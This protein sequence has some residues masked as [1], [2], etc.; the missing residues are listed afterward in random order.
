MNN[1]PVNPKL[2]GLWHGG[3]Y[4]PD[5][6]LD[7]P[8]ILEADIRL[9]KQAKCNVL[10]VG[11]FSWAA[12]EP[13]EGGFEFGWLDRVFDAFEANGLYIDLATP[14]IAPPPWMATQYPEIRRVDAN[15]RRLDF[16]VRSNY[17][18][19]S[20]I[21]RDKV[22]RINTELAKRYGHREALVLW[23]VSNEYAGECHCELCQAAFREF[24]KE[25]HGS[26][27]A[28][29]KAWWT[30]FSGNLYDSWEQISSPT[31]A[32]T[33]H[34][35]KLD[36]RRF[37]TH[38]ACGFVAN[39]LAPLREFSPHVPTTT[40]SP[41]NGLN[42]QAVAACLD[43]ASWDSYPGFHSPSGNI[44]SAEHQALN[45]DLMRSVKPGRPFL[46][47]E[48]TP[49]VHCSPAQKLKR[50]GMHRTAS[51]LAVASGSDGVMYFQWRKSRGGVEKFH[52]AVV[53]HDGGDDT[54]TFREVAELGGTLAK[55]Q[56]VAGTLVK[57]EAAVVYDWE[58]Q[59]A[60]EASA[61]LD[62][63][64]KNYWMDFVHP[65]HKAFFELGVATDVI[66]A[67]MPFEPYKLIVAPTLY[68]V[69]EGVAE[70]LERFVA[71]GGTLV[72]TYWSGI[73][74]GNDLCYLGGAPGP[75]RKLAGLRA[76][77]IDTLYDEDANTLNMVERN[78]LGIEG[79]FAVKTYCEV[80]RTEGAETLATYGSD[81]YQGL[82][83]LTVNKFG[84]GKVYYL[85]AK[86]EDKFLRQFHA[87][88]AAEAKVPFATTFVL[89]EG[90][91]AKRRGDILFL[92]NFAASERSVELGP[93]RWRD[94]ETG[95]TF[96]G[97][98]ALPPF[99]TFC[100]QTASN[101]KGNAR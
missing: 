37:V 91:I 6:W 90:V 49:S 33:A 45:H 53:G 55:L 77:E 97:P 21:Y 50:P 71:A 9:M 13:R 99:T 24:L 79:A 56:E 62:S 34:G 96:S 1:N 75:L 66:S 93:E 10:S 78:P 3:D 101:A 86:V 52:G 29:N 51:L 12:L 61:C 8:D 80:V 60:L 73:V 32:H 36:W 65:Q 17:C 64:H 4:N 14:S 40:N 72:L 26:L 25:R 82:P 28:L 38:Q 5:Q 88:V 2:P 100:L 43:I 27:D 41:A 89:P 7:R 68:M 48:S 20:P 95:E 83:A 44:E 18:W 59:W 23:H 74:D 84:K 11:I 47:M 16:P 63:S 31:R 30:A 54:R 87:K 58:T 42:T 70:R 39:E 22:R 46:M 76:E 15:G 85:A 19:T 81:F 69:R 94:V 92:M 98:L 35:I 57:A 67:D